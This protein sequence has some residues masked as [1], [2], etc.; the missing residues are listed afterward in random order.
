MLVRNEE[1]INQKNQLISR[2]GQKLTELRQNYQKIQYHDSQLA[3][4]IERLNLHQTEITLQLGQSHEDLE[5]ASSR[6]ESICGEIPGLQVEVNLVQN[7]LAELEKNQTHQQWQQL[8][9]LLKMS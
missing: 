3:K 6:L 1:L 4:E 7:K 8:Q 9:N 2:L 5:M